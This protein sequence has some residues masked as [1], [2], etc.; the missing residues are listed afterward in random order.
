[1]IFWA[2]IEPFFQVERAEAV[3][4]MVEEMEG[5]DWQVEGMCGAPA[6]QHNPALFVDLPNHR[7]K[8]QASV[9]VDRY[10]FLIAPVVSPVVS[11]VHISGRIVGGNEAAPHSWP[12]T[13]HIVTGKK[14]FRLFIRNTLFCTLVHVSRSY[15]NSAQ[16]ELL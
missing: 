4:M 7:K 6:I 3:F 10:N 15:F 5:I 8:R 13:A 16:F 2:V 11:P 14:Q 12:W 1:M 9:M